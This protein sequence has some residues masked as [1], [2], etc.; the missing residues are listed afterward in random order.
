MKKL[1]LPLFILISIAGY[2]Q[3][4]NSWIDY[5]KTYYKFKV[6]ATGLYRISQTTLS[7]IGLGTVSADQFQ[8]WRNGE[9]VR[10]Y[11]SSAGG[12]LPLSGYIEFWGLMNDGKK[13]TKL[14]LNADFQLSEHWS[15][16]TD[17]AAYFLTVNGA[18]TNL[19]Y[20][21]AA[22]N[23]SGT[24]LI[25]E[26]YFMNTR[27][28]YYKNKLNPG[29]AAVVG[30]YVY[31]SAYD[32]GEGFSSN[33][34]AP[35]FDL[36]NVF[37][38]I[39]LFPAGPSASFRI[40]A[41][42]N[43]LNSRRVKVKLFGTT[44]LDTAMDYFGYVKAQV[45]NIPLS[46]FI[47]TDLSGISVQNSSIAGDRMVVSF[48]ELTYPSKFN[49]N[50]SKNFYFELPAS[51][52]GNYLV[53]DNFN[54]GNVAP[55]LLD[56]STGNRY[57]ADIS[58]PA[59][60]KFVL[61]ASSAAI[62]KF[63]L[64]S[65]DASNVSIITNAVQRNFVNFSISS[66]QGNYLIISHPGLYNNGAGQNYVD[67][68][69]AYRSTTAGGSFNAK[70][71]DIDQL[72]DQFGYGI[73]NHPSSVK[74]FL[75]FAKT[76][77]T[78]TPKFVFLIGRGVSYYDYQ[79][80]KNSPN[81]DKLGL[82][83]TFG[84]PASDIRLASGYTSMVPSVAV[85]RL[86]VVN[87]NEV[88]NY[89]VKMK[90]YEQAQASTS[91]TVADKAWMKNV[92]HVIGGKDNGE[93][94]LFTNYMNGFKRI[95]EDTLFGGKVETFSKSSTATVQAVASQRIEELFN[96]GLSLI[97][98]FGHS[99][100]N[101]LEFNLSTPET[102]NN[103]G[104]Y[105]FFNVNGCTAGNNY[106]ADTLRL[107]GNMTISEKFVLAN[108]RGS[109]AFLASTHLGIPPFLNNYQTEFY[110]ETSAVSYGS[111][112]GNIINNVIQK[113]GG[114][115][116]GV[117]FFTRIH[118]EEMNLNGDPALKIN[119]HPKPDY[120][121]EEPMIRINPAIVSVAD[122][123]FNIKVNMLNIGKAIK[124][125]IRV[126]VKR[127]LPDN[128]VTN[129]Y[130]KVIVAMKYG[131]SLNLTAQINPITDKGLNKI[132]VIL[133]ADNR[134]SEMSELNNTI[135]K[136]FFIFEDEIRPVYPYN[137][138]IVNNQSNSFYGSTANPLTSQRQVVMEI[139][140]T[141]LFNSAFKKT[142]N[143]TTPGGVIE[144]KPSITYTNNTVYYWRMAMQP[145]SGPFI[146]NGSSFI[147]LQ[148]GGTGFSQSHYYQFLKDSYKQ[149]H[150]GTDGV[151]SFDVASRS[152][153][154]RT[155]LY[156]YYLSDQINVN[157][158]L[159]RLENYGC[160]YNSLQ[161]YVFDSSTLK[162]MPNKMTLTSGSYGSAG[163]CNNVSTR[164]FFEFPYYD[165][166]YRKNAMA[167][168]D[169]IPA[170]KYVAITN[171]GMT[172][173]TSFI[174]SWMNDTTTLG[175]GNSLYHKL[176]SI[177][178]T[179]ID[180]F[181]RNVPFLYFYQKGVASYAPRQVVG[182]V[183]AQLN[184]SF[185]LPA[186]YKDGEMEWTQIGP[187]KTWTALHWSGKDLE[188]S[189]PDSVKVEV[190]GITTTG[191]KIKLATVRSKDTTLSFIDAKTYPYL[192]LKMLNSDQ[193]FATPNQLQYWRVN[194]EYVPEGAM[195]PNIFFKMKDTVDVGE[196]IDF[197]LAFKNISETAF[198]SLKIKFIITDR[199]NVPN[200]I[201]IPKK[202]ALVSGD[203]LIVSYTIDTKDYYGMNTLFVE[204]NPDNDQPEQ[205]HFNN[206][207]YKNF[208]VKGDN[209][210]PLL[211]VTFDGVHILNRDIVSARPHILIKLKDE[212]KYLA[213]SDTSLLKIQVRLPDGTLKTYRFDNDTV[214]FTPANL[215]NGDNTA[216][217]DFTPFLSGDD[218]EYELIVSGKD[219][220]GNKAGEVEY[221]VIFRV[222]GKP[223]IS[224]LLNYPNP[225]T[226][227]T[228]FVFTVTGTQP[229]QN[230]RIQI[231]TITGKVV[232]EITSNEL[233]PIHIGRN[234]TE[235]KWDGT[236][237]YGQKLANGVYLYRVLTNLN[238]KSLDKFKDNGD[239]TDKYFT[240]GYGKMYLLNSAR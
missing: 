134:I 176:K 146:W 88:G 169:S 212:S 75:Q 105:P 178:F 12:P 109:I 168:L 64:V 136:D 108:Q 19:R 190:Y 89:L 231:L 102:Y 27:G 143:T 69:R 116:P 209:F 233:G 172:S 45:N 161:F 118:L 227:S 55:V 73:K 239:D 155:G 98:Y 29:Y 71:Y 131:D 184:E 166:N 150:L 204:V 188:P 72:N 54:T 135:T 127:T 104:K 200:V 234:I 228:A 28:V 229:P 74:D 163:Y 126:I 22:N 31:S 138:S 120:I 154:V 122:N 11:T 171:L 210:N 196:K 112:A 86:S 41:S 9:E 79:F 80:I 179:Q 121:I 124:D 115:N 78:Q 81:A 117:D 62:R 106:T 18:G 165:A 99:S 10:L 147:Y 87:G 36:S 215:A 174:N 219:V 111:A 183:D 157:L 15:L 236:D 91:Q 218:E 1:L 175:S 128:S 49:F 187:A 110:K 220:A 114:A 167:F 123:L 191:N 202:K 226:T 119:P 149:M 67:Q 224:N 77:F 84:F 137:Y 85:G 156:P 42:G 140:T 96:E 53:I 130:D 214:K 181:K 48:M 17:T 159:E 57:T 160:K 16:A 47:S 153:N 192:S 232:R 170:G 100:A 132:T 186:K 189:V 20:N 133:D 185:L 201:S 82:V 240:K 194:A 182:A 113:L 164:Y 30:E 151:F 70:V 217:I 56:I 177:G 221:H 90:Q 211:D 198:D 197:A 103:P 24:S 60:V 162:P 35:G 52:T 173:N 208:L 76:N 141:E 101:T 58:T 14:Y 26:S 203:T 205:Y 4:N 39:N 180:S 230:M 148:N 6:G 61:P 235:F 129:L 51:T 37:D 237:M 83:P 23:V 95:I 33:D 66:N 206:F 7:S 8:L 59:K 94:D 13:D 199:N 152:I 44:I 21:D 139:D 216:T 93:S 63:I 193:T 213:L 223:M 222:V 68:Y 145:A 107:Q 97:T 125:S 40:A 43:S 46:T 65:M 144:F 158:D 3:T 38:T 50:N 92:A 225:F 34:V 2:C 195:A 142:F 238:G 25:P 32:I 5:N 207:I